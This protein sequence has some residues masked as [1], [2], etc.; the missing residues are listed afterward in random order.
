MNRLFRFATL[1]RKTILRD[2]TRV[3]S[4]SRIVA[5]VSL[6]LLALSAAGHDAVAAP[7]CKQYPISWGPAAGAQA[8]GQAELASLSPGASMTWNANTGTLTSIFQLAM[9]LPG[10]TDGQDVSAQVFS[11]LDAHPALFQLDLTEWEMPAPFDCKYI[12]DDAI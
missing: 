10:C 8:A 3:R 9:P 12:G 2:A 7:T 1:P 6:G 4:L 11:V 5:M